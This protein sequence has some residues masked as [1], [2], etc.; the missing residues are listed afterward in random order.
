[1]NKQPNFRKRSPTFKQPFNDTKY[2]KPQ[3]SESTKLGILIAL[4]SILGKEVLAYFPSAHITMLC[5]KLWHT[6]HH[7]F[8]HPQ[9]WTV[10]MGHPPMPQLA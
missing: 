8:E 2:I 4:L 1:M 7:I 3:K 5:D 9:S 6:C 10:Q